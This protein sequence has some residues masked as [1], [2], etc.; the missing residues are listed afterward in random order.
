MVIEHK[1]PK[2]RGGSNIISDKNLTVSCCDCNM[3]KGSRTVEEFKQYLKDLPRLLFKESNKFR[4]LF[5][6][7]EKEFDVL[8]FSI[9][10]QLY[11]EKEGIKI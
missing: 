10:P 2:S 8:D 6:F 1:T 9:D 5:K 4:G 7:Y 11:F 3:L